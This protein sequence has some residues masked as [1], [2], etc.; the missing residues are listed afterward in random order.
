LQSCSALSKLPGKEKLTRGDTTDAAICLI[1]FA[2]IVV[3]LF[4]QVTAGSL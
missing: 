1:Y 4:L 3:S 2:A